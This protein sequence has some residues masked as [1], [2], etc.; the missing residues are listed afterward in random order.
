V[1]STLIQRSFWFSNDSNAIAATAASLTDSAIT[2]GRTHSW[3]SLQGEPGES[4]FPYELRLRDVDS[5]RVADTGQTLVE[6]EPIRL[7]LQMSADYKSKTVPRRWVYIFVIQENGAMQLAY[8]SGNEG[9]HLPVVADET[10][11]TA[12]V[13]SVVELS[14]GGAKSH[15]SISKPFG[16]D[17]Y[18]LLSS[19]TKIDNPDLIFSNSEAKGPTDD[20]LTL[21]LSTVGSSKGITK[22]QAPSSWSIRRYV[23]ASVPK[24]Q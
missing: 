19:D 2:L 3:L 8:G 1:K 6:S 7:F 5:G 22:S 11:K 12:P 24:H 9:N 17:T 13:R 20:Q 21:L 23:Y 10:K 4:V 14:T 15:F 18:F 16:N